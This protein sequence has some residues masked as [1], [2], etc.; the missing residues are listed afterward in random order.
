MARLYFLSSIFIWL[1]NVAPKV[2]H[3]A[4]ERQRETAHSPV[5]GLVA[6]DVQISRGD[7]VCLWRPVLASLIDKLSGSDK[8]ARV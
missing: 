8:G 1:R 7:R 5:A 3:R 6:A 4:S 2:S